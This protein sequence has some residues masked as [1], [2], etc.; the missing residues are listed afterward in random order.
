MGLPVYL[1][2]DKPL[3]MISQMISSKDIL[4][5]VRRSMDG[6]N[7][8]TGVFLLASRCEMVLTA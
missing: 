5:V 4:D 8:E 7:L 3:G 2:K 6:I 1:K